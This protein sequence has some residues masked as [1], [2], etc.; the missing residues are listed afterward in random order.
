MEKVVPNSK[1]VGHSTE[2]IR[3]RKIKGPLVERLSTL[4]V[5]KITVLLMVC[6]LHKKFLRVFLSQKRIEKI[7]SKNWN[8]ATNFVE[9]FYTFYNQ[10]DVKK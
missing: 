5:K 7:F 9:M 8:I 2:I 10:G 1:F 6:T 4:I 3:Q